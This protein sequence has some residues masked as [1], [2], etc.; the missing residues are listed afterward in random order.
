MLLID[1]DRSAAVSPRR[2]EVHPAVG[3]LAAVVAVGL[4]VV[5]F[6]VAVVDGP[7]PVEVVRPIIVG[8]WALAGGLVAVRRPHDRSA[9][10]ILAGA[11]IGGI[12]SLAAAVDEHHS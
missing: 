3:T 9:A 10:V 11:V 6:G 1:Q 8:L 7:L 4:A 5:A 12:G 2:A